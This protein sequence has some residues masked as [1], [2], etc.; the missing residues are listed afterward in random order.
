MN[1]LQKPHNY[2]EKYMKYKTKYIE[3]KNKLMVV[4]GK[5]RCNG[6]GIV[7]GGL[8]ANIAFYS[9]EQLNQPLLI[10]D[11]KDII[12][13]KSLYI[14]ITSILPSCVYK[15]EEKV[16]EGIS[17]TVLKIKKIRPLP[18]QSEPEIF[19]IKL[20]I[21]TDSKDNALNKEEGENIDKIHSHIPYIVPNRVKALFQGKTGKIDF[22]IFNYLGQD[23]KTFLRD[24]SST[25]T[26][27]IILSLITQLHEQLY[28]LNRNTFYHNDVKM[29]NIV[30]KIDEK[31]GSN[32]ELSLIDFGIVTYKNSGK[33]TIESMCLYGCASFLLG[34]IS[35]EEKLKTELIKLQSKAVSSDYVGFFNIIICLLN[36]NY[37][38]YMIYYYI[39]E[40][41]G[42]YTFDNLLKILCLLCYVSN[43]AECDDFLDMPQC[44][45][46]V[47]IIDTNLEDSNI[48]MKFFTPFT[49]DSGREIT[50][51]MQRR[52]LFLCFIYSASIHGTGNVE[53][54]HISKL[55]KFLLDISC[56][57]DLQFNL[58]E[59][60]TNFGR[61]FNEKLLEPA[62][63]QPAQPTQP[64]PTQHAPTQPA[65][66]SEP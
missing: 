14:R 62:P 17:G 51:H 47:Q 11:I 8:D 49:S 28:I 43:S 35:E 37:C 59:F 53:F 13:K 48:Y 15:V 38:A 19:V 52:L 32:Y 33:G 55:P 5:K 57:L 54:V 20:T 7:G 40:I 9:N 24:N 34:V 23:L 12:N 6:G 44:V 1:S 64:V 42:V 27:P 41:N 2:Y 50:K 16:G 65:P 22:A 18:A 25:M 63:T 26:A 45:E 30:V 61:I 3:Y 46:I 36:P 29:P 66:T 58:E 4:N 10:N 56:C 31:T 60:N 39:L 21:L